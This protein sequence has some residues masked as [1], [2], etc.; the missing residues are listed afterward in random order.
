MQ[1]DNRLFFELVEEQLGEGR[2]VCI[3]L[4]G[5]S[6]LTALHDGDTIVLAPLRDE[7][8]PGDI[9]LFRVGGSHIVHRLLRREGDNYILQGDNNM[10]SETAVRDDLLAVLVEVRRRDGRALRTDSLA[11]QRAS[12]RSLHRGRLKRWF[13]RW[14]SRSGRRQLRPW[15][16]ILLAILMWAPL[17]G[18]GIPLDNYILGLRADHLLHASVFLPCSLFLMDFCGSLNPRAYRWLVWASAVSVGLLTEGVQYLL[19]FRGFDVNDLIANTLGVTL[20]WM[21]ILF[22]RRH[23]RQ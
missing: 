18:L 7:P 9:L 6:M 19:P 13:M 2:Q 14:L 4:N 12:R 16:F 23:S 1:L 3:V 22:V 15:Y 10:G 21:V 20:G 17:N 11:W 5:V 8:A